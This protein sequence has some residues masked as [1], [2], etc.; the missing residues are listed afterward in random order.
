MFKMDYLFSP[1]MIGWTYW[2][3][4]RKNNGHKLIV[5]IATMMICLCKSD[6]YCSFLQTSM[7]SSKPSPP[8]PDF[9]SLVGRIIVWA[10]IQE[11]SED[12]FVTWNIL[13]FRMCIT[14][15]CE[16]ADN[17]SLISRYDFPFDYCLTLWWIFYGMKALHYETVLLF[18][19][20]KLFGFTISDSSS[21][22]CFADR[23]AGFFLGGIVPLDEYDLWATY[24]FL[25]LMISLFPNL[26][27][28]TTDCWLAKP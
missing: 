28:V 3:L 25:L 1:H 9:P 11:W 12:S 22:S 24:Q 13:L 6:D 5:L 23:A 7:S 16:R 4:W 18:G 19:Q 15:S 17:L 26:L 14:I 2:V 20:T 10:L 27:T 21:S 8:K